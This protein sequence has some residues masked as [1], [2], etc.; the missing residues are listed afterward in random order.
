[1]TIPHHHKVLLFFLLFICGTG[2]WIHFGL[3]SHKFF[4]VCLSSLSAHTQT[5]TLQELSNQYICLLCATY[6]TECR[7]HKAKWKMVLAPQQLSPGENGPQC[8]IMGLGELSG[9]KGHNSV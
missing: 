4:S 3:L 8:V 2:K 7:G 9:R 5:Q 1:M 6:S